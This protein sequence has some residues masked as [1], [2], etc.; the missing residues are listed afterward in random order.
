MKALSK[1]KLR[2]SQK[3]Q[4]EERS[5]LSSRNSPTPPLPPSRAN[6]ST[7]SHHHET[8]SLSDH[9]ITH[10]IHHKEEY[11]NGCDDDEYIFNKTSSSNVVDVRLLKYERNLLLL[12]LLNTHRH[13]IVDHPNDNINNNNN[14][15][16]DDTNS[17]SSSDHPPSDIMTHH[18]H[19]YL[20]SLQSNSDN[21][22]F[23]IHSN[24]SRITNVSS[25]VQ[26]ILNKQSL[27]DLS[28]FHLLYLPSAEKNETQKESSRMKISTTNSMKTTSTTTQLS[29]PTTTTPSTP[30]PPTI[31]KLDLSNPIPSFSI[32]SVTPPPPKQQ[33]DYEDRSTTANYNISTTINS[34][35]SP[36]IVET[37]TMEEAITTTN[38]T[39]NTIITTNTTTK[40]SQ[41]PP[42]SQLPQ[43]T[44]MKRLKPLPKPALLDTSELFYKTVMGDDVIQFYNNNK[45]PRSPQTSSLP[46]PLHELFHQHVWMTSSSST[47]P[48]NSSLW[49]HISYS[50]LKL[51]S[52]ELV[53]V[54]SNA[55]IEYHTIHNNRNSFDTVL[56]VVRKYCGISKNDHFNMVKR[57]IS[58]NSSNHPL[59]SILSSF[60]TVD[61]VEYYQ[62]LTKLKS[63]QTES[64]PEQKSFL[65][66]WKLIGNNLKIET[67]TTTNNNNTINNNNNTITTATINN[68][69]NTTT[70]N[71]NTIN[72]T[73]TTT[74]TTFQMK[75]KNQIYS[76]FHSLQSLLFNEF[77]LIMKCEEHQHAIQIYTRL[78][79]DLVMPILETLNPSNSSIK[80]TAITNNTP[81][82]TSLLPS[83][84]SFPI[85][86]QLYS[87]LSDTRVL[88]LLK[89]LKNNQLEIPEYFEDIMND[90]TNYDESFE[91]VIEHDAVTM[92]L[93]PIR[94]TLNISETMDT[95]CFIDSIFRMEQNCSTDTDLMLQCDRLLLL[96]FQYYIKKRNV[97]SNYT[98]YSEE[99]KVY[100]DHV[101]GTMRQ[102]LGLNLLDFTSSYSIDHEIFTSHLKLFRY[103]CYIMMKNDFTLTHPSMNLIFESI[104]K[105]SIRK[106]Y[107]RIK[108]QEC[109]HVAFT[110]SSS[111]TSGTS[112]VVEVVVVGGG[113]GGSPLAY[114]YRMT[115][116]PSTPPTP[117]KTMNASNHLNTTTITTTTTNL[118][119]TTT[120]IDT[121]S[122]TTISTPTTTP[123][124][125]NDSKLDIDEP[126]TTIM[127]DS[128][129]IDTQNLIICNQFIKF[130]KELL[131]ELTYQQSTLFSS[132]SNYYEG[133]FIE[134]LYMTFTFYMKDLQS[135]L[136]NYLFPTKTTIDDHS[137]NDTMKNH[138][139][140]FN[141]FSVLQSFL[142]LFNECIFDENVD[143]NDDTSS[144]MDEET[145]TNKTLS[146]VTPNNN[147]KLNSSSS[148]SSTTLNSSSSIFGN[149]KLSYPHRIL[150]IFEPI[151]NLLKQPMNLY[152]NHIQSQFFKYLE[153]AVKLEKWQPL[154]EDVTYSSSY[155]DLFTFIRQGVPSLYSICLPNVL[156]YYKHFN[157]CLS[158][159]M[160]RYCVHIM[161]DLPKPEDFIPQRLY[162]WSSE[163]TSY[164]NSSNSNSSNSSNSNQSNSP[165]S[166]PGGMFKK[167]L[168]SNSTS[169]TSSTTNSSSSSLMNDL[170][171]NPQKTF[172]SISYES[173]F[174]RLANLVNTRRQY[175]KTVKELIEYSEQS[176]LLFIGKSNAT[177]HNPTTLPSIYAS[178]DFY[179]NLEGTCDLL[180][181]FISQL[182]E[183][184]GSR[185]IYCELYHNLFGELYLP[186]VKDFTVAPKMIQEYF[187]PCLESLLDLCDDPVCVEWIITSMFKHLVKAL[188]LIVVEGYLSPDNEFHL[189][190]RCWSGD[191]GDHSSGNSNG[192]SSGTNSSHNSSGREISSHV[193][194]SKILLNDLIQIEKFFYS[195]GEGI[196]DWNFITHTTSHLK[197]IIANVMDKTSE[198]LIHGSMNNPSFDAAPTNGHFGGGSQQLGSSHHHN[199]FTKQ[200]YYKVLYH[201]NDPIAKKFIKNHKYRFD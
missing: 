97:I 141:I 4:Q 13:L 36:T 175:I 178:V 144:M 182:T 28:E 124:T 183:L 114:N 93:K 172:H 56:N 5:A 150:K 59:L 184:I 104:T 22:D 192:N 70:S 180:K 68:N 41:Q 26:C 11:T 113:G 46:S 137:N 128:K 48:R 157:Q 152:I 76:N 74:T 179:S 105:S 40:P 24:L 171:T 166:S 52:Y 120:T 38:T 54:L 196:P 116:T 111:G 136:S 199:V 149:Y 91:H 112:G 60:N 170:I 140:L 30:P 15:S 107:E 89:L 127:N 10:Y 142:M 103:I 110:K 85:N 90:D 173:L 154:N 174:V 63:S 21:M 98:K 165:K 50:D 57:V 55:L 44:M 117:E 12:T 169:T 23:I 16:M 79:S 88:N 2:H 81:T 3:Q 29:T 187:E 143:D 43:P 87:Q 118:N 138:Y 147:N 200:I 69:N 35:S 139:H 160:Q 1:A 102:V 185:N 100:Y 94:Q 159:L 130:G 82:M 61:C 84:Y 129:D 18:I 135:I 162:P 80:T 27:M 95:L 67:I 146:I 73:T 193:S 195:E 121:N 62:V 58:G 133:A 83:S 86:I 7:H 19:S 17:S 45:S 191:G 188:Y 158:G 164:P 131:S 106:Q 96:L 65:Y 167:F 72:T 71:N 75:L 189:K 53:L 20:Q 151:M 119:T 101:F 34:S 198:Q 25:L 47:S 176:R 33:Q 201:R 37:A 99:E 51:I 194:L 39:T 42:S 108:Q 132:L 186:Q 125:L 115:I 109:T 190:W 31:T 155:I 168:K 161:K 156:E 197:N 64:N 148:P 92:A 8:P 14:N 163:S 181:D 66:L 9:N 32:T 177:T 77:E 126:T 123:T 134:S 78:N 153:N 49:Y 122:N 145:P 6:L